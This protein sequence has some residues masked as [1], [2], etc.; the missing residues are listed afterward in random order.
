MSHWRQ[1]LG[2]RMTPI[3]LRR[4]ELLLGAAGMAGIAVS[5]GALAQSADD[6]AMTYRGVTYDTGTDFGYPGYLSRMSWHESDVREE[7]AAIRGRLNCNAIQIVGTDH[8]RLRLAAEIAQE[9]G[10]KIWLQPR[11]MEKPADAQLAHMVEAA[12]HARDLAA[13]G[14]D[15]VFNVG[16][17]ATIFQ[18][19]IVPGATYAERIPRIF[20]AQPDEAARV[21]TELNAYLVRSAEAAR[22]HFSG[23]LTYGAASWEV[24][25][26]SPFDIAGVNLY[27][28][29]S[30]RAGYRETLRGHMQ[31]GVPLVITEFGACTFEGAGR[32]GG[33]GFMIVDYSVEPP[34]IP[35]GFVRSEAE[36][37]REIAELLAIFS[38][39]GVAGAFVYNF[40]SQFDFH[41]DDP[42]RDLD[43]AS[44]AIVKV[45]EAA[46]DAP[47]EW[48]PKQAFHEIA[49][50]YDDL[51]P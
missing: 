30:N 29:D 7:I 11:I 48:E 35:E 15:V 24:V 27:R 31:H 44:H 8:A 19:G 20:S 16:C 10:L 34:R 41:A 2:G 22:K 38:A 12:T 23:P 42:R 26:W 4:R 47:V 36:Q 18:Q 37:A 3:T 9:N 46:E 45:R 43:M 49:R 21:R 40:L 32:Y 51:Q 50:I 13:N 28:D 1:G 33:G 6:G 25:D 17:E 5:T 39:E 14:A